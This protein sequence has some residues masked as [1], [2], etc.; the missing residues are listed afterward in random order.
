MS[1]NDLPTVL[2]APLEA[3]ELDHLARKHGITVDHV[4]EVIKQIHA[5]C[6]VEIEA[7]LEQRFPTRA[8]TSARQVC[9]D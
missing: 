2:E 1:L 7:T 4:K 6:R 8:G 5:I 9:S 3:H